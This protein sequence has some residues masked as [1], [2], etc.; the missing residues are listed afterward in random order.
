MK[1]N[2]GTIVPNYLETP[3]RRTSFRRSMVD[4]GLRYG[5]IVA[6][7]PP[8]A[9]SSQAHQFWEYDV[10]CDVLSDNGSYSK[11]VYPRC[12]LMDAFGGVADREEWTPRIGAVAKDADSLPPDT[13]VFILCVNG[14]TKHAIIIGG[15]KHP[16]S[17]GDDAEL[18]HHYT[19]EFNGTLMTVNSDGEFQILHRGPTEAS[20]A[21]TDDDDSKNSTFIKLSKDGDV[22]LSTGAEQDNVVTLNSQEKKIVLFAS[23]GDIEIV[24]SGNVKIDSSGVLTGDATDY[25]L[26]GTT[27]RNQQQTL[28][29]TIMPLMSTLNGLFMTAGTA[30]TTAGAAHVTP[31]AGPIIGAPAVTAAGTALLNA[32]PIFTQ[33][34]NA[35]QSFEQHASEYLSTKNQH[36]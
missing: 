31:I 16:A 8:K 18:G 4:F 30:L 12:Q 28:H 35:F 14:N 2:D 13:Q 20:G 10:E 17:V 6:S 1:L 11:I 33:L 26:M 34:M 9:D 3:Q 25:Q 15:P 24:A 7:H 21:L 36:D 23:G 29:S 5:R 32:G 19:W 22:I 27:F